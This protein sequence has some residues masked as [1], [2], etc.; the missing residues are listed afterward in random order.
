METMDIKVFNALGKEGINGITKSAVIYRDESARFIYVCYHCGNMFDEIN[1]TLQHIESH[2]Q[3]VNVMVDQTLTTHSQLTVDGN[4]LNDKLALSPS[5]ENFDIKTEIPDEF[6]DIPAMSA[7]SI[8]QTMFS[9]E[10]EPKATESREMKQIKNEKPKRVRKPSA[11]PKKEAK[12]IENPYRCHICSTIFKNASTL[13]GHMNKHTNAEVLRI[14]RCKECDEYFKSA[15][16]LRNHVLKVHLVRK[17]KEGIKCSMEDFNRYE[18]KESFKEELH[19]CEFCTH[20]F[21]IK[22]NLD[23]HVNASHSGERRLQCSTCNAFFTAPKNYYAHQSEH[24]RIGANTSEFDEPAALASI[25]ALID[26]RIS[27][28]NGQPYRC[29][30]CDFTADIHHD[31]RAHIRR[32]HVYP[33]FPAPLELKKEYICDYCGVKLKSKHA[34]SKHFLIHT[35]TKTHPC[36]FCGKLFRLSSTT[37]IHERQHTGEKPYQCHECGKAF[38]SKGL[39]TA[40]K[41][42]HEDTTYPCHIC[43]K[44]FRLPH[45]YR[46]HV[47]THR[48]ERDHKCTIC[49]KTFNTRIYWKRHMDIHS[50]RKHK[51]HFCDSTF[52][53][54][55]GRRQ[56]QRHKHKYEMS[57]P[58]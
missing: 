47:K 46:N 8:I 16:A 18:E 42:I 4:E 5:H 9:E 40:H 48:V 32:K 3:L 33:M 11:V 38:I 51:C 45:G 50:E 22:S 56:H 53:T 29:L 21:Y 34:L 57:L 58:M 52:N 15:P 44:V 6:D 36:R 25:D 7:V 39:L 43:G 19:S 13:R 23:V 20:R 14:N 10:D 30:M 27:H 1:A 12:P 26:E 49:G 28:E 24:Q 2:F 55:D 31:I 37:T 35:N 17:T 54:G 41:K